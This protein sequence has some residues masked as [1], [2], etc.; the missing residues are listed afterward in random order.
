MDDDWG[1]D[2]IYG[3]HAEHTATSLLGLSKV[4]SEV[5]VDACC[6]RCCCRCLP[7]LPPTELRLLLLCCTRLAMSVIDNCRAASALPFLSALR[8]SAVV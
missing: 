6:L 5:D 8:I 7:A 4:C 2:V 3:D 1:G